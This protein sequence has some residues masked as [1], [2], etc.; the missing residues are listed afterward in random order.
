MS[1]T[2]PDLP[3]LLA[4]LEPLGCPCLP[5]LPLATCTTFQLGGPCWLLVDCSR[6][7]QVV[8]AAGLIRRA[9]LPCQL[10]GGGSNLLVSDEGLPAVVLRYRSDTPMLCRE[11]A[12]LRVSAGTAFDEVARQACAW[13]LGGLVNASGIPGTLGG[14]IVG[15]AGAF[16]WQIADALAQVRLLG[17]D[18]RERLATPAEIGFRYRDSGL[19]TSGDIV[20][21]A[22]LQAPETDREALAAERQRILD[23]RHSKHPDWHQIPSA[24]SFFR[25]LE[26]S[27]QAERRQAA[28]FFLEQAGAK[29]LRVGGA[30][31]YG[32]HANMIVKASPD[33]RAQDV[34]DL[35]R[36]MAAAVRAKFGIDL[37]REVLL[38]GHFAEN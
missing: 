36:Q 16:G 25:N 38:L 1:T 6:P 26:P 21:E 28:G 23:L 11:G 24:G 19:K 8:A 12:R 22:W 30:T 4:A 5:A 20:L 7:A 17:P 31:T 18:G 14:A 15:N 37:Q 35:S 32:K 34:Y 27:S 3:A 33:C 10:I 2:P 29:E 9:G 13:G